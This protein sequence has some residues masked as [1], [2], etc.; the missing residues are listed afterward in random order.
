MGVNGWRRPAA[1][2]ATGFQRNSG[3]RLHLN[4]HFNPLGP[5]R[6]IPL[7]PRGIRADEDASTTAQTGLPRTGAGRTAA[8]LN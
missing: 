3:F 8:C 6:G 4:L 7:N 5:G 2:S 1:I